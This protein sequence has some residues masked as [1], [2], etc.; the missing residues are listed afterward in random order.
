MKTKQ[1]LRKCMSTKR[2]NLSKEQVRNE[3][4]KIFTHLI[5]AK[6]YKDAERIFCY[7]S[8]KEEVDTLELIKRAI[9]DK[10]EVAVPKVHGKEME[11]YQIQSLEQL[12]PGYLGILEPI[13]NKIVTRLEGIMIVPG[14][15]FDLE[16]NRMG[17]GGGFYDR[18]FYTHSGHKFIKMAFAYDF[19][20]ILKIKTEEHDQKMDCIITQKGILRKEA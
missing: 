1:E 13:T 10:K 14:L 5:T 17:Y 16:Y 12:K 3:S 9:Q 8:M 18:Y 6:E 7:V 15:A 2:S 20:V 11:F 19:Q 4:K